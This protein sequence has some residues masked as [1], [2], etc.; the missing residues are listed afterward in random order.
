MSISLW[1]TTYYVSPSG[2]DS[3]P[4]TITQPFF[5]LNKAWSKVVAGDIIYMR[6][7]TYRYNNTGSSLTGKSGTSV[8]LIS[9]LAY[10]GEKPV[11]NYN[12]ETFTSQLIGITVSNVSYL[13]MEGIRV[14]GINQPSSSTFQYGLILWNNVTN[15]TFEQMETDHIGG[16][17]TVVGNNCNNILFLNCDSHH[18]ADPL[19]VDSYGGSDGFQ[20]GSWGSGY[21]STNITYRGCRAWNNSDDGWDLRKAD[22]IYTLENCWSFHNGV[23]ENGTTKGGDGEGFKLGGSSS[24]TTSILRTVKNCLA[25]YERSGF[26]PEPDVQ[27]DNNLGLA[28]YNCVAYHNSA[29]GFDFEY[30]N[31]D[32]VKNNVAYANTANTYSW[33]ANATHDHNVGFTSDLSITLTNADFLSIDSTGVTGARQ[34]DGSLP[35]LNFLHLSAGSKL[36]DAG[37]DVGLPYTGK[38]PD[39]GAFE[40]QSGSTP[41]VPAYTSSAVANATPSILEMTYNLTLANIVPAASAFSV[42]VNSAARIVNTVAVSGT[43]VQLTLASAIKYGDIVTVVYTKP[44]TNPL[45]TT[46]GGLAVSISPAQSVV[47]NVIN[48]TKEGIPVTITMTI[49][50]NH[51]H[52]IIN[53]LLTYSAT[54]TTA[55]SPEIIS[56]S[57]L[58]GN[59]FIEKQL[60]TGVTSVKIPI[61]LSSGIYTVVMTSGGQQMATQRMI[62][63]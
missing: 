1:G 46:A 49:T 57:D 8:N 39:L 4:G 25:F 33:G 44:V 29:V 7:G 40:A 58:S 18:N 6:G 2:L 48:S 9:I 11:I 43:K 3:N 41:A 14:T 52:K 21:T 27:P 12:N 31:V 45:Q 16:W 5:T 50:P 10:P 15:S 26:S 63:Y 53:A 30:S 47:N 13:Y 42:M 54:P 32:I 28:V 35:N 55:N 22:G 59:L 61:N 37:V 19:S 62:V 20:S 60:V 36:I 34:A 38:A 17:G 23:R 51:V 24:Y 56:I